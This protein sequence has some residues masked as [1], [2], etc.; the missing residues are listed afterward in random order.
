MPSD[1]KNKIYHHIAVYS[2]LMIE[3]QSNDVVLLKLDFVNVKKIKN[4]DYMPHPIKNAIIFL[5]DFFNGLS[6]RI[7]I[8]L[9]KKGD[10]LP[11]NDSGKLFLDMSEYTDNEIRIYKNL[12]KIKPGKTISYSD[13]SALSGITGGARFAGNC[14][15]GNSF[16][17]IIPCHRVIKKD[18]SLGNYT[19]GVDIKEFL[20]KHEE[21]FSKNS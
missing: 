3:L 16:P 20:L 8:C 21:R 5:D 17:V 12:L 2:G 10:L 7:E 6:N 15:A 4:N 1:F 11:Y 9:Y 13:L 14:M 18:G 19:G